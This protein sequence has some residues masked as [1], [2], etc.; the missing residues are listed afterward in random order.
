MRRN[1]DAVL[2][3]S[4]ARLNGVAHGASEVT[5]MPIFAARHEMLLSSKSIIWPLETGA[6]ILV[7]PAEYRRH[8]RRQC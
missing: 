6:A 1:H 8:S 4:I 5:G 2:R 7:A 3:E